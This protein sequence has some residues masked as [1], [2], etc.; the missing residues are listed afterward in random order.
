[1]PGSVSRVQQVDAHVYNNTRRQGER[2]ESGDRGRKREQLSKLR[3]STDDGR[4]RETVTIKISREREEDTRD[5][6]DDD[7]G[8]DDDDLL[9]VPRF[10]DRTDRARTLPYSTSKKFILHIVLGERVEN[11]RRFYT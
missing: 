6:D 7:N 3:G 8:D 2:G 10:A 11:A 9:R 1:M 4:E 5:N